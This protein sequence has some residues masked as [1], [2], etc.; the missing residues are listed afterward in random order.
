MG[1][2]FVIRVLR[3]GIGR[4]RGWRR[5][6]VQV[7]HHHDLPLPR[8]LPHCETQQPSTIGPWISLSICRARHLPMDIHGRYIGTDEPDLDG[9]IA[10]VPS[11]GLPIAVLIARGVR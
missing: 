5:C 8:I 2:V 9:C 4:G 6:Q 1:N 10:L 11:S 7:V 3:R